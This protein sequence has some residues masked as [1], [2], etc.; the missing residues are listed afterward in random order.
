VKP[1]DLV[2]FGEVTHCCDLND[3]IGLYLGKDKI[4]RWHDGCEI[5]NHLVQ[6]IGQDHITTLDHN[7]LQFLKVYKQ[8]EETNKREE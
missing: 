1:G 2:Q 3:K 8:E 5:T 7:M 6:I 4:M